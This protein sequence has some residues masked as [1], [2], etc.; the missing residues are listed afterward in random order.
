MEVKDNTFVSKTPQKRDLRVQVASVDR[1]KQMSV[2]NVPLTI[3]KRYDSFNVWTADSPSS[4]VI[5]S[6]LETSNFIASFRKRTFATF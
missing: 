6:L 4:G 1:E 3:P 2:V 5:C